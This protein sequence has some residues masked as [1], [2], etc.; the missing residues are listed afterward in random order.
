MTLNILAIDPGQTTGVCLI[1]TTPSDKGFEVDICEEIPWGDRFWHLEALIREGYCPEGPPH[2]PEVV[3]VEQFR[4]RQGRA[5]E[6]SGSDFPSCQVIGI[7]EAF[8]FIRQLPNT[9]YVLQEPGAMSRVMV[10]AND[11][12]WV[13]GSPHKQDAY[14]HARYFYLLEVRPRLLSEG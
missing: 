4:L 13:K 3:V 9:K 8:L 11:I 7:V 6:Q 5:Y 1:H 2:P 12:E 10:S 14:R